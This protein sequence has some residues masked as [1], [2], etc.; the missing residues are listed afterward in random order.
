MTTVSGTYFT[1]E[2]LE[3]ALKG[4][5][6]YSHSNQANKLVL[7]LIKYLVEDTLVAIN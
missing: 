1:R 4:N 2:Q 6:L 5:D 3:A 7:Q